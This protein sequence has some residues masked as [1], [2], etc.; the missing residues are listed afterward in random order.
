M[1][2]LM[3]LRYLQSLSDT[4]LTIV[5]P[6]T[7]AEPPSSLDVIVLD[8]MTVLHFLDPRGSSTFE[9]FAHNVFLPYILQQL[10]ITIDNSVAT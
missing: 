3:S 9:E 10:V 8:G 5:D 7:D 6:A 2:E 1:I 4:P